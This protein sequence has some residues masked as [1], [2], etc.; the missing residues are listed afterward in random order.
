MEMPD[1]DF[2]QINF[3]TSLALTALGLTLGY[4][5]HTIVAIGKYRQIKGYIQKI[6]SICNLYHLR[7]AHANLPIQNIYLNTANNK[8]N[9]WW[10][11]L[12]LNFIRFTA[13]AANEVLGI[14][15][16]QAVSSASLYLTDLGQ[17]IPTNDEAVLT[18]A[19]TF[20]GA[21]RAP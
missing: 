17:Q 20:V 8:V 10:S 5:Y 14:V 2:N 21:N 15:K 13:K 19:M 4:V 1:E 9:T 18:Y 7:Q 11:F 6:T 12:R 16:Q 3:N